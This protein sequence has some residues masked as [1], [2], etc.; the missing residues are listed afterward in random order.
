ML[1]ETIVP[2]EANSIAEITHTLSTEDGIV[3]D[4]GRELRVKLYMGQV[5]DYMYS[6]LI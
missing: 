2:S 6:V 3:V 4:A 5:R 1:A